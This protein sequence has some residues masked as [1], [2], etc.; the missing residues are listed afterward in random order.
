VTQ[1]A[2]RRKTSNKNTMK[3]ITYLD[4]VKRLVS[5]A[6]EIA[7]DVNTQMPTTPK[8]ARLLLQQF[9][10]INGF[11]E[12]EEGKLNEIP[13]LHAYNGPS[14]FYFVHPRSG[15]SHPLFIKLTRK[16][17][18]KNFVLHTFETKCVLED[19]RLKNRYERQEEPQKIL[20]RVKKVPL[21]VGRGIYKYPRALGL[22][23][24][25]TS[26]INHDALGAL[27]PFYTRVVSDSSIRVQKSNHIGAE[28]KMLLNRA[29]FDSRLLKVCKTLQDV[30]FE[31]N[32]SC[33][34]HVHLDARHLEMS[35]REKIKKSMLK[36]MNVLIELVPTSRRDNQY[37]ILRHTNGRYCAVS[38]ATGSK[39][40]IEIRLH[41]ATTDQTKIT[42]WIRLVELLAV[43]PPP[44]P[45]LRNTMAALESLPLCDWDKSFWRSRHKTLNPSM[46]PETQQIA[47]NE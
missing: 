34:L 25:G 1:A 43:L 6:E 4:I 42:M 13:L 15:H 38:T 23:I 8:S 27:L 44:S 33:G 39:N 41:S 10:T 30:G 29:T 19:L 12:L 35:Q 16:H 11:N 22:E 31:V 40:T 45:K 46:Y 28:V 17:L 21:E 47:E 7:F 18:S 20:E 2:S 24:E 3:K 36:W 9:R 37:C 14:K 5:V 32:K 26:P